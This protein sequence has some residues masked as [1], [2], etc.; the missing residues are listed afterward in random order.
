MKRLSALAIVIL[1]ASCGEP[2][3]PATATVSGPEPSASAPAAPPAPP[4]AAPEASPTSSPPPASSPPAS[5]PPVQ[6]SAS[7]EPPRPLQE[8]AGTTVKT[9]G[10]KVVVTNTVELTDKGGSA[11]SSRMPADVIGALRPQF[12]ACFK[13]GMKKDPKL[14]G[15][16][17]MSAKIG[18]DGK[19]VATTPK[20][21]EGLNDAVVKC[22]SEKLKAAQF[23]S[24]G[25]PGYAAS[26][27]IPLAFSSS[28]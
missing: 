27:D 26:I 7:A 3:A 4:V 5:S 28:M 12:S 23:A 16:V 25:S 11:P 6:A 2:K 15:S 1:A 8:G 10:G 13:D 17:T 14:A 19:V 9:E 22:L 21:L 18:Q 20:R 24:A